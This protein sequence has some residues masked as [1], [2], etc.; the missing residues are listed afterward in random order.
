M[1]NNF[2]L[3]KCKKV[4]IFR[5]LVFAS[6][7]QSSGSITNLYLIIPVFKKRI[8]IVWIKWLINIEIDLFLFKYPN[9][10][11]CSDLSKI[12][13]PRQ[14]IT[15]FGSPP[16][17]YWR[18]PNVYKLTSP[19]RLRHPCHPLN[20][21]NPRKLAEIRN[22]EIKTKISKLVELKS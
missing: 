15:N 3:K 4:W 13:D 7:S 1:N 19:T 16:K 6:T 5:N 20:P 22:R 17:I 2:R 8:Q 11:Y 21:C 18:T 10:F 14:P 9:F 12:L